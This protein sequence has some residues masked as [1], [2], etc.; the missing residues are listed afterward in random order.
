MGTA[1]KGRK[2]KISGIPEDDEQKKAK[3]LNR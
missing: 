2:E 1:R 3:F